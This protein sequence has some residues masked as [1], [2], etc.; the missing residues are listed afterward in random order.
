MMLITDIRA[1]FGN[2]GDVYFQKYL[3]MR[4]NLINTMNQ[5]LILWKT[6]FI[7]LALVV[8]Y[9]EVNS[10]TNTRGSIGELLLYPNQ[11]YAFEIGLSLV[12]VFGIILLYIENRAL[13]IIL[14]LIICFIVLL[15]YPIYD[16]EGLDQPL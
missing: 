6:F 11:A 1:E 16:M 14:L 10:Y 7:V 2:F 4:S 15:F 8:L 9:F 12:L 13:V 5:K 3:S